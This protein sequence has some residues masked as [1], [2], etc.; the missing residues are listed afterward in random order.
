MGQRSEIEVRVALKEDSEEIS[1][2]ELIGSAVKVCE[3]NIF[4]TD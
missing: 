2:I 3:G 4:V 1:T